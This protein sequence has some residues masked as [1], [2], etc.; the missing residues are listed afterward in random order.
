MTWIFLGKNVVKLIFSIKSPNV[1]FNIVGQSNGIYNVFKLTL[2][3]DEL[4]ILLL[5][6]A[7]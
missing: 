5:L 1:F 3:T 6:I 4:V 7:Q 2:G